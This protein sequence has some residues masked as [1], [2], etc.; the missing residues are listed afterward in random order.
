MSSDPKKCLQNSYFCG[1]VFRTRN[2][3][4]KL[5]TGMIRNP[6]AYRRAVAAFSPAGTR[7][8][9]AF[10]VLPELLVDLE[11]ELQARRGAADVAQIDVD[12]PRQLDLRVLAHADPDDRAFRVGRGAD[13]LHR[14][15][16]RL[17]PAAQPEGHRIPGRERGEHGAELRDRLHGLSGGTDDH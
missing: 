1:S 9:S 16:E 12:L 4:R 6:P 15:L 14:A 13:R 10:D 17:S 11:R 3:C 7:N 2:A 5:S 8:T